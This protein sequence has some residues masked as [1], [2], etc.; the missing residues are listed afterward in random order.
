MAARARSLSSRESPLRGTRGSAFALSGF[1]AV[2]SPA[3]FWTGGGSSSAGGANAPVQAGPSGGGVRI[4]GVQIGPAGSDRP[5][6]DQPGVEGSGGMSRPR[7]VLDLGEDG[8][9]LE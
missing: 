4:G 6:M 9:E 8:G 5:S 3:G 1:G 2:L 7:E